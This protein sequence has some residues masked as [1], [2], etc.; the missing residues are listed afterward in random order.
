MLIF[1]ILCASA[2]VFA[3]WAHI[4]YHELDIKLFDSR[5]DSTALSKNL[6]EAEDILTSGASKNVVKVPD[7]SEAAKIVSA[8]QSSISDSCWKDILIQTIENHHNR[9]IMESKI[10]EIQACML[11]IATI[12]QKT[13]ITKNLMVYLIKT[14]I[15]KMMNFFAASENMHSLL[16]YL[17][18]C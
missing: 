9:G 5:S 2:I 7:I 10:Q 18:L 12:L 15:S 4:P 6:G 8:A 1:N 3:A 14:E 17:F 16:F 13:R 11:E